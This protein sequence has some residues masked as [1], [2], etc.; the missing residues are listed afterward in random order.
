MEILARDRF[1]SLQ[2]PFPPFGVCG[3]FRRRSSVHRGN[4]ARPVPLRS[5]EYGILR[6]PLQILNPR[7]PRSPRA[8]DLPVS[9]AT[10]DHPREV[11]AFYNHDR[12]PRPRQH[13]ALWQAALP[14]RCLS[15]MKTLRIICPFQIT[16]NV[17][18]S[19]T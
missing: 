12:V 3:R 6:V 13:R 18:S 14:I 16:A 9:V 7:F 4:N 1:H 2:V 10:L 19:Y 15:A 11:A 8:P 17:A 5:F